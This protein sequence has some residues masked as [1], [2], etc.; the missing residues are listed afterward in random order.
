MI[1]RVN[2]IDYFVDVKGEGFPLVFL[3]GF[4]GD[5]RTW[6]DITSRIGKTHQ[7]ITIDIIGHGKS[8]CPLDAERY[9][10][11]AVSRDISNILNQL[12][13][14]RAAFIGYSMGGRLAL[15][16]SNLYPEYVSVLILESASPGLKTEEAQKERRERDL[17][18][19]DKI[20]QEGME[21]FVN[22][23]EE[24]PLFSTQKRLPGE[25]QETIRVQRLQQSPVGLSNSLKGM[26]TGAQPSWW[27]RLHELSFPVVLMIGELDHK[28]AAI[29]KEM[30]KHIP[31]VEVITF[32]DT[33]HAI[34]VEEPRKFG[35]IIEEVLFNY[36]KEDV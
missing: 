5:S 19:A 27:D 29:A 10:M 34:H 13:I 9:S 36:I 16:F 24:I 3:H 8:E 21:Y 30:E 7:C 26:G 4:T 20:M 17:A 1:L 23:W 15:H 28:F 32:F 22:F 35:T 25:V 18:L 2:E 6:D 12:D 33:G 14:K 31:E 11:D